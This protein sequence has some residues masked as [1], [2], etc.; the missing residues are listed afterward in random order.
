MPQDKRIVTFSFE[1]EFF[2]F[3]F[4]LPHPFLG[5]LEN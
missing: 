5:P 4:N 2:N 1:E 3:V